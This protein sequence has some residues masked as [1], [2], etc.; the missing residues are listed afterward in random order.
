MNPRSLYPDLRSRFGLP[1]N[2]VMT[3][4]TVGLPPTAEAWL[5][6]RD[7]F[8][9]MLLDTMDA[10]QKRIIDRAAFDREKS[11]LMLAR[12]K[13]DGRYEHA[14]RIAAK[15]AQRFPSGRRR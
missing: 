13:A 4:R 3:D 14:L 10:L 6:A 15:K 5:R 12:R 8:D 9:G 11:R 7:D 2:I 1:K